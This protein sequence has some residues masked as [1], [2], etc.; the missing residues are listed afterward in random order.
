MSLL[1]F[2]QELESL[3]RIMHVDAINYSLLGEEAE[4]EED[5][6][7]TVNASIQVTT[8]YYDGE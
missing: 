6:T 7:D 2:I 1:Q 8:F 4:F 3:D 5:V